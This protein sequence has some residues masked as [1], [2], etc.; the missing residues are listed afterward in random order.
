MVT[1]RPLVPILLFVLL[2]G[3]GAAAT[4]PA[5]G[6]GDW[7]QFRGDPALTGVA[8]TTLADAPKLLWTFEAGESVESSAAIVGGTVYVGSQPGALHA[9]DLA[10]GKARWK[11]AIAKRSI[12]ASPLGRS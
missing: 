11:Y 2:V 4:A 6:A 9:L 8:R 10:T 1:R 5:S 7:P 3:T 12:D